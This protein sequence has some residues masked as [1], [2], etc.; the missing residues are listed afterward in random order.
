MHGGIVVK[1]NV[2]QRYATTGA[3][4]AVLRH[5][6]ELAQ[7]PLQKVW[8][9]VDVEY[10]YLMQLTMRNDSPCGSTIGPIL[11][12]KLGIRTVDVGAPQLAM[13]SIREMC[14]ITDIAYAIKL[15]TVTSIKIFLFDIITINNFIYKVSI[16]LLNL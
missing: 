8:M 4:Y 1:V 2:N 11:S 6:A 10:I 9:C 14:S 5:I 15:F 7:V 3:T 12:S 16:S 13:H